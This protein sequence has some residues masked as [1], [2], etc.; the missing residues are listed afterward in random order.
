VSGPRSQPALPIRSN[1]EKIIFWFL[2]IFGLFFE[3][4]SPFL[5]KNRPKKGQKPET[6]SCKKT[7]FSKFDR[8]GKTGWP[9]GPLTPNLVQISQLVSKCT[10]FANPRFGSDHP[11][12]D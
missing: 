4:E 12:F 7:E 3:L 8:M 10:P 6:E 9:Q 1:F 2:A 11:L 5:A